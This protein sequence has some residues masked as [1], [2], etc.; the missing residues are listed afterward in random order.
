MNKYELKAKI[1]RTE[2]LLNVITTQWGICEPDVL[3]KVVLKLEIELEELYAEQRRRQA[4]ELRVKRK[5][6]RT[7]KVSNT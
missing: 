2:D 4:R 3:R 7:R 6:N 5:A 1:I